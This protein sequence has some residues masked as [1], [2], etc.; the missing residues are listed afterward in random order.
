MKKQIFTMI[1]MLSVYAAS[2]QT[3]G[4]L[5]TTFGDSGKVHVD[6]GGTSYGL[7]MTVQNDEKIVM[8]G[9][10]INQNLPSFGVMRFDPDGQLDNSFGTNGIAFNTYPNSI[11]SGR[12]VLIQSDGKILVIGMRFQD[13]QPDVMSIARY[14]TDGSVDISFGTDGTANCIFGDNYNEVRSAALQPDGK[15]IL[16]GISYNFD[17]GGFVARFNPDGSIDNSFSGDGILVVESDVFSEI[18]DVIIQPDGKI[19]AVGMSDVSGQSGNSNGSDIMLIRLN[20][21]GSMDNSFDNDGKVVTEVPGNSLAANSVALQVDGKIVIAGNRF[22]SGQAEFLSARYNMDGS[23]DNSF[24]ING[25]KIFSF[26]NWYSTT[27]SIA[28]QPGGDILIGGTTDIANGFGK[29]ALV[30]LTPSGDF[31]LAFDGDGIVETQFTSTSDTTSASIYS[32]HV[33]PNGK[34]LAGGFAKQ[35]NVFGF[36]L[37]RYHTGNFLG[38]LENENQYQ[39]FPVKLFPNPSRD[40]INVEFQL[41]TMS[42]VTIQIADLTGRVFQQQ[43][44]NG[45]ASEGHN[46]QSINLPSSLSSG[47]YV[48]TLRTKDG[49]SSIQFIKN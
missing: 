11:Y 2:A 15:I 30:C 1:T 34:V 8:C 46:L 32:V 14:N 48:L 29:F 39:S 4:T 25:M 7:S 43:M 45:M 17:N 38:N 26:S 33:L 24:G 21:D 13:M 10:L 19:V 42:E 6:L 5:D 27:H 3:P 23:I 12:K 9:A 40:I 22:L 16:A 35:E 28:V 20:N 49:L 36:A 31:N 18:N 37:A 47:I 41:A 44:Y